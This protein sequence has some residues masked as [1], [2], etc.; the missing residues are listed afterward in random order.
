MEKES[1]TEEMKIHDQWYKEARNMT[2]DKLPDFINRLLNDYNHDYG[3]ICHALTAG[4]IA[5]VWA[6]DHSPQG[7]IT[8]FQ[9]GAIMWEFIRHWN[10]SHNKTGLKIIDYDNFLYPQYEGHYQK[11]LST[12]TWEAI[13]KQARISIEEATRNYAQYELDVQQ[14][15]KDLEEFVAKHPDYTEDP[16]KYERL[17]GGTQPEWDEYHKKETEGFEFAPSKP[18]CS[19]TPYSRVYQHWLS[20]VSGT[21]PFGYS[22]GDD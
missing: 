18:Y 3:T 15:A 19:V 7:G 4:A 12:S 2:P 11:T 20:I 14:Y 17:F 21:V 22:V 16:Q 9:A 6:M 13:Q 5:T 1:I 8:G 10:Y